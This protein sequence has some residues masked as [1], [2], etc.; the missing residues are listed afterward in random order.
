MS[1]FFHALK[2][3]WLK[4]RRTF[5][6]YSPIVFAALFSIPLLATFGT[7]FDGFSQFGLP[8]SLIVA[9]SPFISWMYVGLPMLCIVI[10]LLSFEAEHKQG[11]WKHVNA[12]PA[13]GFIQA[14]AKHF[15]GWCYAAAGTA[16]LAVL[17]LL[18]LLGFSLAFPN[19]DWGIAS[20]NFWLTLSKAFAVCLITGM[21]LT[22]MFNVVAARFAGYKAPS[23]AAVGVFLVEIILAYADKAT[24]EIVNPWI[25]WMAGR[26]FIRH[27]FF[28]NVAL[29]P[30]W[31]LAPFLWIAA[32]TALH[33]YLQKKK[34]LY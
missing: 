29:K 6:R 27:L 15:F 19:I 22:S 32:G 11:M 9:M 23:L 24:L 28:S 18:A 17:I 25:P 12:L 34:P 31:L 1:D 4:G 3:E 2:A 5:L 20:W 7:T 30:W 16:V 8:P 21:A 14:L 13:P 33:L 10:P 26:L